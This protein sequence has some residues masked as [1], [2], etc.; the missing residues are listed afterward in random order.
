MTFIAF[1]SHMKVL[2][3]VPITDEVLF[4]LV[5]GLMVL[6]SCYVLLAIAR[7]WERLLTERYKTQPTQTIYCG[8]GVGVDFHGVAHG[9]CPSYCECGFQ[10]GI[11]IK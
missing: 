8:A 9:R 1:V 6:A 10:A 3:G 4:E 2:G 11:V 7:S 5:A